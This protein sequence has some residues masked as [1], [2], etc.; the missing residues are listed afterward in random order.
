[1]PML[2]TGWVWPAA[3]LLGALLLGSDALAG[4][5]AAPWPGGGAFQAA[6]G[7]NACAEAEDDEDEGD[8]ETSA[9]ENGENGENGN[10]E[11]GDGRK[12]RRR[13]RRRG[14]D[15]DS[16]GI[17]PDA[18]QPSDDALEALAQRLADR[19]GPYALEPIDPTG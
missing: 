9:A 16:S 11:N 15:R 1:M 10:G 14:R 19:D 2:R 13:R 8:E 17:D 12:R 18:P 6:S 5:P 3:L 4:I 7:D